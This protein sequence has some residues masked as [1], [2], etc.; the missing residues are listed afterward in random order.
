MGKYIPSSPEASLSKLCCINGLFM[1]KKKKDIYQSF[2]GWWLAFSIHKANVSH[3][4]LFFVIH[5][6]TILPALLYR[7]A[8]KSPPRANKKNQKILTTN[9]GSDNFPLPPFY[10]YN[11]VQRAEYLH[12]SGPKETQSSWNVLAIFVYVPTFLFLQ[13]ENWGLSDEFKRTE[14]KRMKL[15]LNSH[16]FVISIL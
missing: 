12:L 1:L 15:P 7:K 13:S 5:L 14:T 10:N 8:K 16:P 6:L 4:R 9:S 3:L 2:R 11:S